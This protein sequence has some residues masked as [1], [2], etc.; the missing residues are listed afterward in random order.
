MG[1]HLPAGRGGTAGSAP[2]HQPAPS[3]AAREVFKHQMFLFCVWYLPECGIA[4]YPPSQYLH[5]APGSDGGGT[6]VDG[7]DRAVQKYLEEESEWQVR[8]HRL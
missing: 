5:P 4:Y 2:P 1:T 8:L 6:S 3:H 7:M